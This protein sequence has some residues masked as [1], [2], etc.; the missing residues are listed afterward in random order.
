MYTQGPPR[1]RKPPPAVSDAAH[2]TEFFQSD[3]H[4]VVD[5]PVKQF[6]HVMHEARG[7]R[8]GR[9]GKELLLVEV[10]FR[11]DDFANVSALSRKLIAKEPNRESMRALT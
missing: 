10:K 4:M 3:V 7:L 2:L 9:K 11:R 1:P 8:N 6:S 5:L